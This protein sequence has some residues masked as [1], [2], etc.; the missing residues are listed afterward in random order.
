MA[1]DAQFIT[2]YFNSRK[3]IAVIVK[4]IECNGV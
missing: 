1:G 2:N 4:S 3:R